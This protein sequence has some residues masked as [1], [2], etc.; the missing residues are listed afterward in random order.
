M[1]SDFFSL[2]HR[3]R[4]IYRWNGTNVIY[5]EDVAQHCFDVAL[6]THLLCE[7]YNNMNET[8]IN[9]GDAVIC[10]LYHDYTDSIL[11]HIPAPI[12]NDNNNIKNAID[13]LKIECKK[14]ILQSLPDEMKN[15]QGQVFNKMNDKKIK[16]VI[17]I[18]DKIDSYR[19]AKMELLRGNLEFTNAHKNFKADMDQIYNEKEYVRFFIDTFMSNLDNSLQAEFRYLK[20]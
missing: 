12:K 20:S 10:A 16:E 8:K 14:Y 15:K 17:E 2:M 13:E 4:Y 6:I 11:T 9:C 7:I 5:K 1:Y 3:L 19:K 18:A